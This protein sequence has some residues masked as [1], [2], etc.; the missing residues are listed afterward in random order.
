M[1]GIT[2]SGYM[3]KVLRVDLSRDKRENVLLEESLVRR[4]VGGSGLGLWYLYNEVT[5]EIEWSDPEN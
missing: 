1:E 2:N 4:F 3:G 5:P